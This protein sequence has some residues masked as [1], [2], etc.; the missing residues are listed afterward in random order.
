MLF[1]HKRS[2][3]RHHIS[4]M[5]DIIFHTNSLENLNTWQTLRR[6]RDKISKGRLETDSKIMVVASR[7]LQA[8]YSMIMAKY[9]DISQLLWT[10]LH[11]ELRAHYEGIHRSPVDSPS[12]EPVMWAW[13]WFL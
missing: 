10:N 5:L 7:L 2:T 6:K 9:C 12:K 13:L 11:S 3:P 4:C 1:F 8:F